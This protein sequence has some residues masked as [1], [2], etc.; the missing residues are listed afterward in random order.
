MSR[1]RTSVNFKLLIFMPSISYL[2]NF[3]V[4][5]QNKTNDRN[6]QFALFS[7]MI[8]DLR[9]SSDNGTKSGI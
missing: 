1:N 3:G 7:R 2:S 8:Y 6:L 4:K 5:R 9:N